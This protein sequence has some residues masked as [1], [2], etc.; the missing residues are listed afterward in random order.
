MR[1]V[2]MH[3]YFTKSTPI[4]LIASTRFFTGRVS[5]TLQILYGYKEYMLWFEA[6]IFSFSLL[7]IFFTLFIV[8]FWKMF[9]KTGRPGWYSL[10]PIFSQYE[11]VKVAN[12][13][14]WWTLLLFVPILGYVFL[15]LVDLEIAKAFGKSPLF[16]VILLWWIP[17]GFLI[18]GYGKSKYNPEIFF[19]N[20][21]TNT[22][23]D[24]NKST[25]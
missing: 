19:T 3:L 16:G 17:I 2:V 21:D 20:S 24:A 8:G 10:I 15:L 11:L 12:K 4:L 6:H 5:L 23:P 22:P 25:L 1:L 13:P 14:G 18:I 9:K 7:T